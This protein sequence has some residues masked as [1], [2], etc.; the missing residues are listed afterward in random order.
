MQETRRVK[1]LFLIYNIAVNIF[2]VIILVATLL[3]YGLESI[4]KIL[5]LRALNLEPPEK[6][7]DIYPADKYRKSQEYTRESTSFSFITGAFG[8]TLLLAFWFMRGFNW[9]DLL[10]RS[11]EFEAV[12]NGLLYMGILALAYGVI[13][14]PFSIYATFN[15]EQRYGFNRTTTGTFIADI[16]KGVVLGVILGAPLL[17]A[18]LA[19]FESVGQLAWVYCWAVSTVYLIVIEFIAPNWIMPIFNKFTPL[20]EGEL[21]TAILNYARSVDFPIQNVFV[22]DGS[23]RSSRSN[24]FFTGFGNNKRIALFDTLIARHSVPELV[25]VLAHEIGHYKKGHIIQG[26]I[27]SI[28]HFGLLFFL[29]SL[30]IDNPGL[31]QAF[32]MDQPSK[33]AGLVFFGLLYTPLEMLLALFL[34]MLSRKNETDADLFA[35][36]TIQEPHSLSMSLKKLAADNL[37]NLTPHPFF[38]FLYYSH[39]PLLQRLQRI[40]SLAPADINK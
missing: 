13:M 36:T 7:K 19:L 33:Y 32:F 25:A 9:M 29:L 24:A 38:V 20:P 26:L 2:A 40:E 8:L 16:V 22:M 30:F 35:S 4:A 18:I 1:S 14:L 17:A 31:H 6:L 15:I 11:W 27:I 23:R 28:L 5:N 34:N 21:R 12:I 10:V 37:S 39:P 3:E